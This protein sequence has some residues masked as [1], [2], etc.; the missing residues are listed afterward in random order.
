MPPKRR[1]G[2]GAGAGGQI[3]SEPPPSASNDG[4]QP[5]G[6]TPLSICLLLVCA[7]CSGVLY[8]NTASHGIVLDDESVV[9]LNKYVTD[10]NTSL[11][12]LLLVSFFCQ[13][14]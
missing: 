1:P 5:S 6:L 14:T 10:P 12:D 2:K 4:D 9:K 11:S 13:I 8:S 7:I 3:T